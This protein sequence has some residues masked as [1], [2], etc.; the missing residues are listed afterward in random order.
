M[1]DKS[2]RHPATMHTFRRWLR[3]HKSRPRPR[4]H[5]FCRVTSIFLSL[6]MA[7]HVS[8]LGSHPPQHRPKRYCRKH[9]FPL[10][11]NAPSVL[12]AGP[13]PPPPKVLQKTS[14]GQ[15]TGSDCSHKSDSDIEP[16]TCRGW[17]IIGTHGANQRRMKSKIRQGGLSLWWGNAPPA[18]TRS[19][20]ERQPV[21]RHHAS[22]EVE[23]QACQMHVGPLCPPE[24]AVSPDKGATSFVVA[25]PRLSFLSFAD[26]ACSAD[27]VL[28]VPI[29]PAC[30]TP[31]KGD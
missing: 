20:T 18:R 22:D 26:A 17:S 31:N 3:H 9:A 21:E 27:R 13:Q 7:A 15:V 8:D 28:P 19:P 11:A 1:T 23:H 5:A 29:L 30:T 4:W 12:P 2:R 14:A 6:P 24:S 25:F 10:A 16:P